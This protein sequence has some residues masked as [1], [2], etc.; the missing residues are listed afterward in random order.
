MNAGRFIQASAAPPGRVV[1]LVF[2]SKHLPA[3][4]LG[5]RVAQS[6]SVET[7]ASVLLVRLSPS[8]GQ[9]S[10]E[11]IINGSFNLPAQLPQT[12]AGF[13][14][15]NLAV[16]SEASPPGWI[17][18]LVEQLRRRFRH[19]LIEAVTEELQT[20]ALFEFLFH[21]DAGYFFVRPVSEDV[22]HLDLLIREWRQ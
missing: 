16:N 6:L 15:L 2:L 20:P 5:D 8:G 10:G 3:P 21:S 11:I 22:Y 18:A 4:L 7:G 14:F 19:V 13:H 1:T 9:P 17:G 12:E